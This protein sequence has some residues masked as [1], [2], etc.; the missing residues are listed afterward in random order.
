VV[1]SILGWLVG[2]SFAVPE[3]WALWDNIYDCVCV[4]TYCPVILDGHF[5][6]VSL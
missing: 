5:S 4:T 1:S 3:F 6:S 2:C